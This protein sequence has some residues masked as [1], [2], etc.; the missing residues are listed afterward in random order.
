MKNY[1]ASATQANANQKDAVPLIISR[2]RKISSIMAL[3]MAGVTMIT[4]IDANAIDTAATEVANTDV[5]KKV[6][7]SKNLKPQ[8]SAE[9]VSALK[10]QV[11]Q[12]KQQLAASKQREQQLLKSSVTAGAASVPVTQAENSGE[13][14]LDVAQ[15]ETIPE[16][17]EVK[18]EKPKNLG[19]VVVRS[20]QRI[21]K[22]QDV[23]L[24]ISVVTGQ[25]LEREQSMDLSSITRRA[26]NINWNQGNQRTS[27]LSIRG[28][29]KVGQTEAQDP[30]VGI[31]VD[32]INYAYNPMS[33]SYDFTDVEAVEVTRGP[34]GTLQGKGA[35]MGVVNIFTKRPTFTN[36]ADYSFTYGNYDSYI[37]KG[38][39]GGAVIDDLLAFR[40]AFVAQ[41]QRGFMT[42]QW[43]QD[44]TFQN[45]D[46][47]TG[48]AQFLLTPTQ[49]FNA[50]LSVNITPNT[51]ENTNGGVYNTFPPQGF[52]YT[53]GNTI[54]SVTNFRQRLAR[55]WF[56]GSGLNYGLS[57][58]IYGDNGMN[59]VD[60][61]T[62]QPV[63]SGS[64]GAS[65]EM[66][67]D[68]ADHH[69]TSITGFQGYH[70]N[71]PTNDDGTPYNINTN[72][73]GY[74]NNYHQLSQELRINSK[75][76]GFI[77]YTAGLFLM[78]NENQ[79]AFNKSYGSDA[80]AWF[81]SN[82][83]Y[84]ALTNPSGATSAVINSGNLL[85]QNSLNNLWLDTNHQDIQNQS[86]AIFGQ[87]NT[88]LNDDLTLT[89]G[90]RVTNEHR[91]NPNSAYIINEGTGALLDPT[92]INGVNTGYGFNATYAN[93]TGASGCNSS[94]TLI[95]AAT[96][97]AG[98]LQT[99]TAQQ[100][101]NADKLA[102]QYYG[103]NYAALTS[104]QAAQ[105]AAARSIRLSQIGGLF[106]TAKPVYNGILPS[107]NISPSYKL[108]ENY[109]AYVS[110]Q[111]G[112]KAGIA[113][114]LNGV[115]YIASPETDDSYEIGLKSTLFDRK[116]VLNADLF[117]A[118]IKNYQTQ[119]ATYN[120]YTAYTNQLTNA[121]NNTSVYS[122]ITG[123]VPLARTAGLEIDGVF[124]G[125]PYTSIRFAGAYTDAIY[126]EYNNAPNPTEVQVTTA[127]QSGYN[128]SGRTLPGASKF[129]ANI[130]PEVRVASEILGLG[131]Y[132]PKTEFHTSFTE[133]YLS[134][135]NSDSSLSAYAWIPYQ[136]NTDFSFG[137][138][139]RDKK[140]DIS[141]VAKNLL[142][143]HTPSVQTMTSYTP[144]YPQWLGLQ[145]SGKF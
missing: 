6:K 18:Q 43:N 137:I 31:I 77:D 30:S 52:K 2:R 131:D 55:P 93:A 44:S 37:G 104:Q 14:P 143:N 114:S 103:V 11:E 86:E 67:W 64:E 60:L 87:A 40:G 42:N 109:T 4:A 12:L 63:I 29:G 51:G 16:E 8:K 92:N 36:T 94:T 144:S 140:F 19:E 115:G 128:A 108:S 91:E 97:C 48:R 13:P 141:F 9:D 123:N 120:S 73:G 100:A 71:A 53:N 113:Q 116:L 129:T 82:A 118:N 95:G 58:Y 124:T 125:L 117:W 23:P 1:L 32:G 5:K 89:T 22:L 75:A 96:G 102:Q 10:D 145:F 69:L 112:M 83:Q 134:R 45:I 79:T 72:A 81:A 7:K 80:G 122:S 38:A 126:V 59:S 107:W 105:I 68:V 119:V 84:T 34:Q 26:A 127:N 78:Q 142:N 66:N 101:A 17:K 132:L 25:D 49:N 57:N 85:L 21:E 110:W 56:T 99:N 76:G 139:R 106:S 98:Q 65:L 27:S 61:N 62:Q 133:S 24:S 88:H 54:T 74:S 15:A 111:H 121:A 70:F 135:Y 50:R 90:F 46:R 33:S 3:A 39:F 130:S 28:I 41:K 47:L 138:G 20:R 136:F 35:T